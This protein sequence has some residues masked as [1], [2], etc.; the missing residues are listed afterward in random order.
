MS[1]IKSPSRLALFVLLLCST[2]ALPEHIFGQCGTPPPTEP[3]TSGTRGGMRIPTWNPLNPTDTI[4]VNCVIILVDFPDDNTDPD[5]PV[6]PAEFDPTE[7]PWQT[8]IGWAPNYRPPHPDMMADIIDI[9][10]VNP[11]PTGKKWNITT[12]FRD[13]SYGKF[14]LIGHV[15]YQQARYPF[16]DTT[17]RPDKITYTTTASMKSNSRYYAALHVIQDIQERIDSGEISNVFEGTDNWNRIG[18]RD[19]LPGEDNSIDLVVLCYRNSRWDHPHWNFW[20][21]LADLEGINVTVDDGTTDLASVRS[22]FGVTAQNMKNYPNR[23]SI[24][25]IWHEIGH[26]LGVT[27]Q[28]WDGMWSVMTHGGEGFLTMNSWERW[29]LGWLDFFDYDPAT[30]MQ[31][32]GDTL[33]ICDLAVHPQAIRIRLPDTSEGDQ[34]FFVEHHRQV[35]SGYITNLPP[36]SLPWYDPK[37][38]MTY[39]II[40]DSVICPGM[41][42][43][44]RDGRGGVVPPDA[45]GDWDEG[46]F[47]VIAADGRWHWVADGWVTAPWST[48]QQLRLYRRGEA[49][50]SPSGPPQDSTLY[51]QWNTYRTDR[52]K[53]DMVTDSSEYDYIWSWKESAGPGD[54]ITN[55]DTANSGRTRRTGDGGDAWSPSWNNMFSPW[56]NPNT[57]AYGTGTTGIAVQLLSQ[58]DT[59]TTVKI[60]LSGSLNGP[61]SKPQ[62]LLV[63]ID[64]LTKPVLTWETNPE[65]D[66]DSAGMYVIQRCE[67]MCDQDS[68]WFAQDTVGGDVSIWTDTLTVNLLAYSHRYRIKAYDTQDLESVWSEWFHLHGGGDTE[69][70]PPPSGSKAVV[71]NLSTTAG[72]VE[73]T[74][75]P[76]PVESTCL[77]EWRNSEEGAVSIRIFDMKG[78][79]VAWP[80]NTFSPAGRHSA[81]VD[82][83]DLPAGTYICTLMHNGR[84]WS[85]PVTV[86]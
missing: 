68:N 11:A 70:D 16:S 29:Q 66:V 58:N 43:T 1:F 9:S 36:D 59:S 82:V 71:E 32:N 4:T 81:T 85:V 74:V 21:G 84:L 33:T 38:V 6:W 45:D 65:P 61:P 10:T 31:G 75:G 39:D 7:H 37:D 56:S 52:Q 41:Y 77:I 5:N 60:W 28:Y 40:D 2:F 78:R 47:R 24:D 62:H 12:Y 20:N 57:A 15:V 25:I 80:V 67:G 26:L 55:L 17:Y 79:Q 14:N 35:A 51:E 42:I 53:L 27:H 54:L 44:H 30:S 34:Y 72:K 76:N 83:S 63:H 50:R 13:M 64:S 3:D 46:D 69:Q 48:T 23:E 19:F 22:V 49:A 73:L 18:N 8:N 86:K